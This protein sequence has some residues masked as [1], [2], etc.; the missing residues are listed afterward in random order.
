MKEGKLGYPSV[1][2]PWLKYYS[3]DDYKLGKESVTVYE[4]IFRMNNRAL[5]SY[6]INYYGN[7]ITYGEM[8]RHVDGLVNTLNA[9]GLKKGQCINLCTGGCPEAFY[10]VLASS[11]VGTIANFINPMFSKEQMIDRINDT[12]SKWLFVLDVMYDYIKEAIEETCIEIV[13]IIPVSNSFPKPLAIVSNLKNSAR[14]IMRKKNSCEFILWNDF[15]DIGKGYIGKTECDYEKDMPMI[16]VYS[17]GTTGASKGILL[18]N[19]GINATLAY[20]QRKEFKLNRNDTF[21]QMIPVWFSTGIVLS[22]L[23]PFVLGVTVIPELRFSKESFRKDL[24]KYRPTMTLTATSLWIYAINNIKKSINLSEMKYPISGGE[25]L[26]PF[27][28]D[29]INEFL[30]KNG[31]KKSI[32]KGYGMCELGGTISSSSDAKNYIGKPGGAG[33]P[34]IN[35]VVSA[36]DIESGEELPFYEHGEIRVLSPARMKEYYKNHK[37]TEEFFKTD[38][39]G[40]V[41]GCTGDIGYVDE[42]GEVYILG[43]ATDQYRRENGEIVFLFDIEEVI[44]K[45]EAVSQCKVIDTEIEGKTELV[46]HIVLREGNDESVLKRI[47]ENLGESLPIYMIPEY[48]KIRQS[49]PVHPNGKRDAEALKND[50]EGLIKHNML[51]P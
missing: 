7:K 15:V 25:R 28:E 14:N 29:R 22:V 3:E 13:V 47:E 9:V 1:E 8:F 26:L 24:I 30:Q 50:K 41:W 51:L 46:A 2:K 27:D 45:D 12:D 16:M 31:C 49:M 19:D 32:Y 39:E 10:T 17:S 23:M 40:R 4:N 33:Y 36:F 35:V 42:D 20:Y 44:L 48:Y 11:R 37:A 18:T 34:I 5:N 21:L 38:K 43:R 6:A